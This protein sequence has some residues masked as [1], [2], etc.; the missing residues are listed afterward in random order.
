M[1]GA[2]RA[3]KTLITAAT[4]ISW[5]VL[6]A[7]PQAFGKKGGGYAGPPLDKPAPVD[8]KA[9]KAALDRIP[10][11][12]RPYDPWAIARPPEPATAKKSNRR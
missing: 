4:I 2:T 11:P 5:L 10:A 6:P 12:D 9:Y 1:I 7:C 8:E 3:I